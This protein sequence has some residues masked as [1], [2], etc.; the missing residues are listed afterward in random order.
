MPIILFLLTIA[1]VEPM[2]P[3]PFEPTPQVEIQPAPAPSGPMPD[4]S[5][6]R[7][8]LLR[9][10][11]KEVE[12]NLPK[13]DVEKLN[14]SVMRLGSYRAD[15]VSKGQEF[16][17]ANAPLAELYLYKYTQARN[18]RL[19]MKILDTLMQ[20]QSYRFP[21]APL[22]FISSLAMDLEQKKMAM[23]LIQKIAAS[24][25][26]ILPEVLQLVESS[27][28][29]ELPLEYRLYFATQVCSQLPRSSAN[30]RSSI[31]AWTQSARQY[32]EQ[33]ISAELNACLRGV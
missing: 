21:R 22:A 24:N 18:Y 4:F 1:Q 29:L 26:Q 6:E 23:N 17:V 27:W 31:Q 28:G 20:F 14:R 19:N 2:E 13:A 10:L 11:A 16:L 25:P 15:W 30:V 5:Q 8:R 9:T 33:A 32:W 12:P 7:D 3:V